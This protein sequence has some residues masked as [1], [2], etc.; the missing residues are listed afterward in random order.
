MRSFYQNRGYLEFNVESTQVSITPDKED[1]Y[2]TVNII[3]GAQ[4]T[5]GDVRLAG[6]LMVPEAELRAADPAQARRRLLAR[7]A[8]ADRQGHQRPAGQRKGYAFANVNAVPEIDQ[9]RSKVAAF[10][11]LRR[12]RAPR[13]HPPD[14]HQRQRADAATR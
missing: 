2:I 12:L 6:D 11:I 9:T 10:T 1:I 5:V 7:E 8:A 14:Q 4:F 13:L 3:E